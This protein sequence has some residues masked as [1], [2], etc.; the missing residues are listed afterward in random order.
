MSGLPGNLICS[1]ALVLCRGQ[2][3]AT[4]LRDE[5]SILHHSGDWCSMVYYDDTLCTG[6][7]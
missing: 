6:S 5:A 1:G 4:K 3:T 7:V 2:E